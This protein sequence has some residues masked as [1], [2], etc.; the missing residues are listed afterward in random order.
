ML[1]TNC[2]VLPAR[3]LSMAARTQIPLNGHTRVSSSPHSC[4]LQGGPE[5]AFPSIFQEFDNEMGAIPKTRKE[6]KILQLLGSIREKPKWWVHVGA[7]TAGAH[8]SQRHTNRCQRMPN[9]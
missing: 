8:A 4:C 1:L 3:P 2:I 5:S 9:T 6:L 7:D